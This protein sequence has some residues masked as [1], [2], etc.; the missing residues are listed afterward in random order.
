M[1]NVELAWAAGFIDGEGCIGIWKRKDRPSYRF[2]IQVEN[3]DFRPLNKLC[4]MFGGSVWTSKRVKKFKTL[5]GWK[6]EGQKAA[7][8]LNLV[9]P[10]LIV[11]KE[12][13]EVAIEYANYRWSSEY[14][15]GPGQE[16]QNSE[17]SDALK[18]LKRQGEYPNGH[19]D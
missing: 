18:L 3:T 8:V 13:A 9:F 2:H 12:Q 15:R 7:Q 5:Y 11:K 1:T 16:Q 17:F 19:S 14:K 4:S 6:I 10:Y